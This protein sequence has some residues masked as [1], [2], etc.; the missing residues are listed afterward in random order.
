MHT[1]DSIVT[2]ISYLR[3]PAKRRLID[4][5]RRLKGKSGLEIGGPSSL[6]SIKGYLP[7]YLF[8]G[9]ID[10][11][12]FSTETVWEGQ[13]HEGENYKWHRKSGHQY[14]REA[15]DL[16]G[17]AEERYDFVLS[18][19]SLEH[20]ANPLKAL[21][22]WKRV[23]KPGGVLILVLPDKRY[24]FD[25]GRP[26]TRMEHLLEDYKND[27][28]ENDTTHF[29]EIMRCYHADKDPHLSS[30]EELVEKLKH[31][32]TERCAHHHVFSFELV[33][34]LMQHLGFETL[35]QQEAAPFHLVTIA[36]KIRS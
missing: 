12:N 22:E 15:T 23:L 32:F 31:N 26:Y 11:V 14:I 34:E 27:I 35:Y 5:A 24:T 28:D 17:I 4:W 29:D 8:A 10:G 1:G 16:T 6:F 30:R 36:Q 3:Q 19:H 18:C 9:S 2:M 13:I 21:Y 7:V 20:V 33:K 25:V